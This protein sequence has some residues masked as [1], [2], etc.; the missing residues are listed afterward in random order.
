MP[1]LSSRQ[2]LGNPP[3]ILDNATLFNGNH[4]IGQTVQELD[5]LSTVAMENLDLDYSDD[6]KV[7]G[8]VAQMAE[9]VIP[10]TAT[11]SSHISIRYLLILA[12][13]DRYFFLLVRA[14]PL[15]S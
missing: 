15:L 3:P 8:N 10:H 5:G 6:L 7:Q 9:S 1:H 11:I 12:P 14:L 13:P 4:R 2:F